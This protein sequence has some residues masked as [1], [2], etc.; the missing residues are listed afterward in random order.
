ME[1]RVI[2]AQWFVLGG[3]LAWPLATRVGRWAQRTPGGAAVTP[4]QRYIDEYPN[5][6]ISRTTRKYFR[7]WSM[8]TCFVSGCALAQYMT[9]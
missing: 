2:W 8:L 7:R 4:I 1:Y 3:V 5:V 6:E 9:D